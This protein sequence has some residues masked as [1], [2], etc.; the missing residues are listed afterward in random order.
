MSKTSAPPESPKGNDKKLP[1]FWV[2]FIANSILPILVLTIAFLVV[3]TLMRTRP[4]APQRTR[5]R[6]PRLVEVEALFPETRPV[7]IEAMGT[8]LP[9]REVLLRPRVSGEIL[10]IADAFLPGGI[11][12]E[13]EQMLQIDPR[14]YELEVLQMEAL[15]AQAN[16][17][18]RLELGQQDVAQR[19][20]ELLGDNVD[21]SAL[22]YILR[23]PQKLSAEANLKSAEARLESA[24]LNLE[25][26]HVYAPFDALVVSREVN[27]GT[28][29]NANTNLARIVGTDEFWVELEVPVDALRWIEYSGTGNRNGSVVRIYDPAAWGAG[30]YRTGEVLRTTGEVDPRSRMATIIVSVGDPRALEHE[31]RG[32]PALL[33]NSYVRAEIV[34]RTLEGVTAVPRD[35][36]RDG[37]TIWIYNEEEQLEI[38]AIEPVYRARDALLV[39]NGIEPGERIVT[40]TMATPVEGMALRT[41]GM[42]DRKF[43]PDQRRQLR[44]QP[45]SSRSEE[46]Q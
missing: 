10:S 40:T 46:T 9:S 45:D 34:G 1:P 44:D 32:R 25:R 8:T 39:T 6:L 17:N 42:G 31:N 5:E 2:R 7:V 3:S 13:G 20:Y 30:L 12:E 18:L 11:F 24:R 15:V 33:L 28:V 41:S 23:E 43:S 36:V 4:T 19:D 38:R 27:Q 35:Y 26:T 22:E 16:S 29:V 37:D 14:D 21:E